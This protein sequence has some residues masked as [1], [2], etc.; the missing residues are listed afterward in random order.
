VERGPARGAAR[1]EELFPESRFNARSRGEVHV[2]HWRV[3][4]NGRRHHC[5]SHAHF[6]NLLNYLSPIARDVARRCR[7]N[8]IMRKWLREFDLRRDIV[9]EKS[10]VLKQGC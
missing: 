1:L 3:V 4:P 5:Q 7:T 6:G 10:A 8:S 9:R 2:I